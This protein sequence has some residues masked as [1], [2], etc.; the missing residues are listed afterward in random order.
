M[1]AFPTRLVHINYWLATSYIHVT[2]PQENSGVQSE[3]LSAMTNAVYL[4]RFF[5]FYGTFFIF[6]RF[7]L[8]KY[9]EMETLTKESKSLKL[10]NQIYWASLIIKNKSWVF[11]V[12]SQAPQLHRKYQNYK[13]QHFRLILSFFQLHCVKHASK[14]LCIQHPLWSRVL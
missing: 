3:L 1:Q 4:W 14:Y 6:R 9:I 12:T 7:S 10:T 5:C 2:F 8:F 13:D 11:S